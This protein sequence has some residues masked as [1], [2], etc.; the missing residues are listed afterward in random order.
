MNAKALSK[1][2]CYETI[3]RHIFIAYPAYSRIYEPFIILADDLEEAKT[4]VQQRWPD[5][6]MRISQAHQLGHPQ[7]YD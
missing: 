3:A 4:I 7:L 5:R 1:R 2:E 6:E